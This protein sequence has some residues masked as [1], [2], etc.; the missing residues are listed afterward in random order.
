M[1]VL[2]DEDKGVGLQSCF[3]E[4]ILNQMEELS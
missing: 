3:S 1:L 2:V 4:V